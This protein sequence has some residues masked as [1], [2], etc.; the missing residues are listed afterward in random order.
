MQQSRQTTATN[1]V[2]AQIPEA[3]GGAI[4]LSLAIALRLFGAPA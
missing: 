2:A 1:P 4:D 3:K